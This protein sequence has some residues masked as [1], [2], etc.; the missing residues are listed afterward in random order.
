MKFSKVYLV[1]IRL[2]NA[3]IKYWKWVLKETN[4]T[5]FINSIGKTYFTFY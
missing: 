4:E 5:K 2:F 1:F 3:N